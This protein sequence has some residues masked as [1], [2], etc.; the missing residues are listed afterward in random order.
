MRLSTHNHLG[1]FSLRAGTWL[2]A[3]GAA[4]WSVLRSPRYPIASVFTRRGVQVLSDN[5]LFRILF[6]QDLY[7]AVFKALQTGWGRKRSPCA[8]K[9]RPPVRWPEFVFSSSHLFYYLPP[10]YFIRQHRFQQAAQIA[11]PAT[12][13]RSLKLNLSTFFHLALR[14][15]KHIYLLYV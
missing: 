9:I 5:G 11:R 1:R 10:G 6:S 14:T 8:T 12:P 4:G 7:A 15:I 13:E 2:P 3:S